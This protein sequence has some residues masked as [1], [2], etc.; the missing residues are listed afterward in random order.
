MIF[1][2][3]LD[4]VAYSLDCVFNY[5]ALLPVDLSMF[6]IDH[7]LQTIDNIENMLM[8]DRGMEGQMVYSCTS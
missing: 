1:A 7:T 4:C 2:S 3:C 6:V 5:A 8:T